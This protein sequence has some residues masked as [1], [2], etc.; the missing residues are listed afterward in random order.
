[1]VDAQQRNLDRR[2]A[3]LMESFNV[4]G[5][6]VSTPFGQSAVDFQTQA[7]LE[8]NALLSQM[9][10]QAL[11][12]AMGRQYGAANTLGQMANQGISQLSGQ[13]FQNDMWQ[14]NH[15]YNLA[16][17][18]Y[19]GS[20]TGA[21]GLQQGAMDAAGQLYGT[22]TGAGQNEI[23]RQLAMLQLGFGGAND[24]SRLWMQNLG[25]GSALGQQQYGLGQNEI[26]RVYQEW[27]RSRAYNSP[28]LPYMYSAATDYPISAYPQYQQSQWP[29]L[30]GSFAGPLQSILS[31]LFTSG[32]SRNTANA[33]FIP[34]QDG[35]GNAIG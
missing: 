20:V 7:G 29:S 14:M 17:Q 22:E 10:A 26:D 15:L 18:M 9:T 5:N 11:E 19:G 34:G 8:Q 31:G 32:G 30:L 28:M 35:Y 27:L 25:I 13:D 4:S 16:N 33:N 2:Y 12:Q 23:Q 24:L 3:D 1:M 21:Q 6:R